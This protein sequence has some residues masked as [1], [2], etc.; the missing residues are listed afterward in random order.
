MATV[1]TSK[2]NGNCYNLDLFKKKFNVDILLPLFDKDELLHRS[3]L[4]RSRTQNRSVKILSIFFVWWH[5]LVFTL[6]ATL[7]SGSMYAPTC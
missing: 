5:Q 1:K 7:Y 4:D 3:P 2:E 6:H